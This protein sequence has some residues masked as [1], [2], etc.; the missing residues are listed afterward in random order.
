MQLQVKLQKKSRTDVFRTEQKT[1]NV[2]PNIFR[3]FE[4]REK[5]RYMFRMPK[6][7]RKRKCDVFSDY[8]QRNKVCSVYSESKL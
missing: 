1:N 6:D 8:L 5:V 3:S 7:S 2:P 4:V